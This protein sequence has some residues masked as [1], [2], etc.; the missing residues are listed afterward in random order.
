MRHGVL[1]AE[2]QLPSCDYAPYYGSSYRSKYKHHDYDK[3]QK[4]SMSHFGGNKG[5]KK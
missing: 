3:H 2:R 1:P 5:G 4:G